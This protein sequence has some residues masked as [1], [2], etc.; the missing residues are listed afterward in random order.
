MKKR[1]CVLLLAVVI[2]VGI[3]MM[4]SAFGL[5][6]GVQAG[7]GAAMGTTDDENKSGKLRW[8]A[9]GGIAFDIY[10]LEVNQLSLGFAGGVD[11]VMLNYYGEAENVPNPAFVPFGPPATTDRTSESTYNYVNLALA[12]VGSYQFNSN[13]ALIMRA[14][15]FAGYF[16]KGVADQTYS[17]EIDTDNGYAIDVYSDGEVDLD[18][19]NT[20]QWMFGLR[21][22]A[23]A[24]VMKR[25]KISVVPGIQFDMGLTDTSKDDAQPLP[26]KDTFWALTANVGVKYSIF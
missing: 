25:G 16:L 12:A 10:V 2:L 11:Y 3:P 24:E 22:Y 1:F 13:F 20:E 21:F 9:G 19:S 17:P 26:S 8:A 15:G 6:V 23:G 4:A 18:D 7:G 5:D 14:G